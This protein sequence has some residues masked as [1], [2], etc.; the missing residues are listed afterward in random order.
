[1]SEKFSWSASFGR[2]WGV[3]LQ[4]HLFFILCAA[5][6]FGIE[7]NHPRYEAV[8]GTALVTI[9]VVFFIALMHEL[10][11]GF[12]AATLGG[13]LNSLEIM[14]WGGNSEV[15]LPLQHREQLI[16]HAAGPFFNAAAFAIGLLLLTMTGQASVPELINPLQPFPM[17]AGD[18]EVSLMKIVTWVNFQM[19]LVNL[20][21][22]FPFDA[23]RILRSAVLAYNRRTPALSLE[24][25]LLFICVSTGLLM[26]LFA[27]L[28]RDYESV[29]VNPTWLLLGV[30]G[31]L[32]IF[33][34]RYGFH[35]EV[36]EAQKELQILD[37]LMNYEMMY[38]NEDDE[39]ETDPW[40]GDEEEESIADWLYDQQTATENAERSVA[41]EEERRVDSILEKLHSEGIEALEFATFGASLDTNHRTH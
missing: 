39:D 40:L 21:P 12:A 2:W 29:L 5:A 4:V 16:V 15:T 1:M 36:V 19:L 9:I 10:S 7:W 22:V 17:V 31:I 25:A 32:L 37:E 13:R 14:P 30:A 35:Q 6:V 26:I 38:D 34:A 28:L 20:L 11:H 8:Q 18:Y 27:W 41:L 23:H 24:S 3:P 33:S